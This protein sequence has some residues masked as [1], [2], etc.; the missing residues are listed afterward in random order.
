MDTGMHN[1]FLH[2]IDVLLAEDSPTIEELEFQVFGIWAQ[3]M[4]HTT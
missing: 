2:N 4:V 1:N 3:S